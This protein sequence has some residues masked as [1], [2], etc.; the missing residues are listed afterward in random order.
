MR[1]GLKKETR[2]LVGGGAFFLF[3]MG[4]ILGIPQ[5]FAFQVK[6][7]QTGEVKLNQSPTAPTLTT[8]ISINAE[9]R[10][11]SIIWVS[12]RSSSD[13][14]GDAFCGGEFLSDTSL[15]IFRGRATR[16]TWVR[17]YVVEFRDDVGVQRGISTIP[18]D[19]RELVVNLQTSIDTNKSILVI[20]PMTS[21]NVAR[22]DDF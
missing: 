4:G 8:T 11:Q 12:S 2:F 20:H 22:A 17:W 1:R 6:S 10:S 14:Y 21:S 16:D 3:L 7:V 9:N 19:T 5:A 13:R 15:R 18:A